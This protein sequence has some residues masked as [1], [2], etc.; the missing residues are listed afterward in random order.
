M[1]GKR[2]L[3]AL[4]TL[5]GSV[6]PSL[7]KA[8]REAQKTLEP[9]GKSIDGWG[10]KLQ[11]AGKSMEKF[12]KT[13]TKTVTAPILA[14]GAMI[15]NT[16]T[17]YDDAIR[18][19]QATIQATPRELALL[20][21]AAK[22]M[23]IATRYTASDAALALNAI[24]QAGNDAYQSIALLPDV[25]SAA[26]AG[27]L[28]LEEAA[29]LV[30]E[31]MAAMGVEA[32]QANVLID[33][34]ARGGQ[35]TNSDI[36]GLG[37][38]LTTVGADARKLKDG[39][40]E[41]ITQLGILSNYGIKDTEGGTI[42]RN[43]LKN[44]TDTKGQK[45][46]QKLGVSVYDLQ[47]KLRGT[48]EIFADLQGVLKGFGEDQQK[49]DAVMQSIFDARNIKGA[50]ALLNESVASYD[51]LSR[52]IRASG[53]TA[54]QMAA[55]M[56]SGIGGAFREMK[57][58]VEG[59]A[60]EFGETLAPSLRKAAN[61]ITK[62]TRSLAAM[63]PRLK[64]TIV[65]VAGLAAA[66]GPLWMIGG[67]ILGGIGKILPAISGLITGGINPLHT[68]MTG[69]GGP[70]GVI[71]LAAVAL[72]GI[73]SAISSAR[74]E[75]TK[76][77]LTERFGDIQLSAE[78]L[79]AALSNL[80]TGLTD[81]LDQ[82]RE[83]KTFLGQIQD[84]LAGQDEVVKEMLVKIAPHAVMEDADATALAHEIDTLVNGVLGGLEQERKT[85]HL[86]VDA[87][88]ANNPEAAGNW[89]KQIDDYYGGHN[90][91]AAAKGA[92]LN[93]AW[94]DA[95]ADGI[96]EEKEK[97]IIARLQEDLMRI[98]TEA[99]LYDVGAG[100][101][102]LKTRVARGEY[103]LETIQDLREQIK[104]ETDKDLQ[105]L[106]ETKDQM[107]IFAAKQYNAG[108]ISEEKYNQMLDES[109]AGYNAGKL[110]MESKAAETWA[111]LLDTGMSA[112]FKD[113]MAGFQEVMNGG[114]MSYMDQVRAD[115]IDT[116][117][118]DA[119]TPDERAM[120]AE[121]AKFQYE[122]GIYSAMGDITKADREQAQLLL[123]QTE[124][125]RQELEALAVKLANTEDGV[126]DWLQ[127]TLNTYEAL[128]LM[129]DQ[130][131]GMDT[132]THMVDAKTT[133]DDAV[134]AGSYWNQGLT[135]ALSD[136]QAALDAAQNTADVVVMLTKIAW[137]TGS[138]SQVS[139][140]L[141]MFWG[142][143]LTNGITGEIPNAAAAS[144]GLSQAAIAPV[145]Q[146][147]GTL[148]LVSVYW[149]MAWQGLMNRMATTLSSGEGIARQAMNAI[150]TV[151]NEAISRINSLKITIPKGLPGAGGK[152]LAPKMASIAM[153]AEGATLNRPTT[154]I[155]AEAGYPETVVP[156]TRTPRSRG[157][158]LEALRG[159]GARI[160]GGG[161]FTFAPVTH[162]T[163][164]GKGDEGSIRKALDERDETLYALFLSCMER[165]NEEEGSE[166]LAW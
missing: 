9:I 151:I 137:N 101:T 29:S 14:A 63:D 121:Q 15:T 65:K 32:K 135:Q 70:L 120:L 37:A 100:L 58:A 111:T 98:Y 7:Q 144:L 66:A 38:G 84:D 156:H 22:E 157:L 129:V 131:H 40:V 142:Q 64:E 62:V 83:E 41:L 43:L 10:Q 89:R 69:L 86:A 68:A 49:I 91:L 149:G 52:T 159:T 76:Q 19:V 115:F 2:E 163:I 112:A 59:L 81:T 117:G 109:A 85:M 108:D 90:A 154:A 39:T 31:S 148:G 116:Y 103:S 158:A 53:G 26:Q 12:G 27:G 166:S 155:L 35:A 165:F 106:Q 105:T 145:M 152:N 71:T 13:M 93:Q 102:L 80:R 57:S 24:G 126:P 60:I 139:T 143:G 36:A 20:S 88:L 92:E 73:G 47:G 118:R 5:A 54:A 150:F 42:F 113:E 74:A 147:I 123:K 87:I 138:P 136:N 46:L 134:Q 146:S 114:V 119:E 162:I 18:Q 125:E 30:T 161:S 77:G 61:F 94:A 96:V 6:D 11:S 16:F 132:L 82:F 78:Q 72:Y 45:A 44:L 110:G 128:K 50:S 122:Q 95:I 25:L 164:E 56:E 4:I 1:A 104:A 130:G 75:A 79:E 17:Q 51:A 8:M 28:G 48:N 33:Q 55:D 99:S 133:F 21:D 107:D 23:G 124:T 160:G 140:D 153:L 67:K 34:L 141:G 97:E 3:E 127:N